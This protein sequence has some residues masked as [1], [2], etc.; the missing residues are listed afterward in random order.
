MI[1]R[2][3]LIAKMSSEWWIDWLN[4]DHQTQRRRVCSALGVPCDVDDLADETKNASLAGRVM[5]RE[6]MAF[7]AATISELRAIDNESDESNSL[8]RRAK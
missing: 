2:D 5:A 1:D 3:A 4:S 6:L 7:A 8:G